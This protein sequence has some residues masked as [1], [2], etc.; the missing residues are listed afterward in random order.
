GLLLLRVREMMERL[1]REGCGVVSGGR[2]EVADVGEVVPHEAHARREAIEACPRKLQHGFRG[3]DPDERRLGQGIEDRLRYETGTDAEIEDDACTDPC[4]A[5][6][7]EQDLLLLG[8]CR[9]PGAAARV[10]LPRGLSL[11]PHRSGRYLANR[12]G[13]AG[14]PSDY[15]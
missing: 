13:Q 10:P 14:A 3:V 8:A 15:D 6:Q 11:V 1:H 7:R 9:K 5:E 12:R 4:L 2:R